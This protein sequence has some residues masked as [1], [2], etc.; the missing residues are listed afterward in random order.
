M[1]REPLK[2][3]LLMAVLFMLLSCAGAADS[4]VPVVGLFSWEQSAAAQEAEQVISLMERHGLTELYQY[5][6]R[7]ASDEEVE[8]FLTL[9]ARR[10]IRVYLL[11]GSAEWALESEGDSLCGVIRR[12]ARWN[13]G[14]PEGVGFAGV[15]AD[16]EP[17][18]LDEWQD[19]RREALMRSYAQ[20]LDAAH[21]YAAG[22]DLELLVCV[23]FF[24]DTSGCM[25]TLAQ[26][27][28]QG[29]DGL[30]VMNYLR[31][32]E[33]GQ[34]RAEAE[35]AQKYGR[36]IITIYELQSPGTDGLTDRHSYY[37][38]GLGALRESY[39]AI[40]E[41]YAPQRVDFALHYYPLLLELDRR[42]AAAY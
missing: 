30:A 2:K 20:G 23:P 7:E 25:E 15:M 8:D 4:A 16:V 6:S 41:A 37:S 19:D 22:Q 18:L 38:A 42:E 33:I 34:I 36:R 1:R 12:A 3:W 28:A 13:D 29:C 40:Q 14:L 31:V 26:M 24:Y 17:Y 32:D 5:F 39:A 10:G 21:G 11:A 27:A 35:L 9:A